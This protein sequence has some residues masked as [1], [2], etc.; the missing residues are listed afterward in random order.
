MTDVS[1]KKKYISSIDVLLLFVL[2]YTYEITLET[3]VYEV[4]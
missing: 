1:S 4:E 3:V 2:N